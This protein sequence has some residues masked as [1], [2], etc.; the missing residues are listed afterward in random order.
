MP[1]EQLVYLN[2]GDVIRASQWNEMVR[3]L[4]RKNMESEGA[5]DTDGTSRRSRNYPP[6]YRQL[7]I[8]NAGN[9]TG[10]GSNLGVGVGGVLAARYP[11]SS[12]EDTDGMMPSGLDDMLNRPLDLVGVTPVIGHDLAC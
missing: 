7:T 12:P 9:D 11:M 10:D 4:K 5:E 6:P 3:L 2:P 1:S 8:H